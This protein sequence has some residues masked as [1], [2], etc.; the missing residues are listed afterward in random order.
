MED[1][2]LLALM[3]GLGILATGYI[4]L[5]LILPFISRKTDTS[6]SIEALRASSWLVIGGLIIVI[7]GFLY[8]MGLIPPPT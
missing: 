7:L 3:I 4:S 2:G 8:L 1:I 6:I 5:V